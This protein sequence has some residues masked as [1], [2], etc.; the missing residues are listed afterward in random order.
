MLDRL[1][2]GLPTLQLFVSSGLESPELAQ[3][4]ALSNDMGLFLQ[5]IN[6]TRDYLEDIEELPAPR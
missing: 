6:I 5:K 4:E 2:L 1:R 3:E